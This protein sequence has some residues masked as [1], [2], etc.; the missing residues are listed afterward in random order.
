MSKITLEDLGEEPCMFKDCC[1]SL[2]RP[3]IGALADTLP[4]SPALVLS[5]GSGTGLL[6]N[7]I[8]QAA[9]DADLYGVEV[10]S[11]NN[12]HLPAD[13]VVRV[14][15]SLELHPDAVLAETLIFCYPRTIQLV[16]AYLRE[17][18]GG[19]LEKVV[20]ISHR[21]EWPA[22]RELFL[23]HFAES[24]LAVDWPN[25]LPGY[26]ILCIASCPSS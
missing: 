9:G 7:L 25:L 13:R 2:S 21:D 10:P 26:E 15:T 12:I 19:A 23:A 20:F 14:S 18:V 24:D 8:R 16:D 5:I 4:R 3:L 22:F 1:C 17:C 6:E 11:C